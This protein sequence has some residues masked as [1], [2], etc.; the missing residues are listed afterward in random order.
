[1][2]SPDSPQSK[3]H[4]IFEKQQLANAERWLGL[5]EA[6]D[7]PSDI[8]IQDY[9]NLLRALEISL[10]KLETF[11]LAYRL[12]LQLFPNVI[13]YGDWERWLVYLQEAVSLSQTL[14]RFKEEA[15]LMRFMGNIYTFKGDYNQ[16]NQVYRQCM[17]KYLFLND[18]AN[19]ADTLTKL[20]T[21]DDYQGNTQES[22]ALL[23]EALLLS[24]SINDS[25][26]LMQIN[27]SLSSVYY[28][29]REWDQGI[30][31]A[32]IAY[33][34]AK[35][36]G[37]SQA[38]MQ[39]L[40]N[41]GAFHIE[42]GNWREVDGISSD[43]EVAL[44]KAGDVIRLGQFKN[45]LGIAAF[46][47]GQYFVAER[48]WQDALQINSQVNQPIELARIYNNLGMVYTKL[49]ELDAAEDMLKQAVSIFEEKGDL[50]NL[51][52]TLDNLADVYKAQ[53]DKAEF[54]RV[55]REALRLLPENSSEPHIQNLVEIINGR[56][57]SSS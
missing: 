40:I 31:S 2:T 48:A 50:F 45:N 3:W 22:L 16:A 53:G 7:N 57:A 11:D 28:K 14:N 32:E 30:K 38:E 41:I 33:N 21:V 18:N 42:L 52:N 23:E 13:G 29:S 5:L 43:L 19:Y 24:H 4:E 26:V 6:E 54:Q 20:A 56:L 37:D 55:L 49:N 8:L 15:S 27:L 35:H 25:K 46:T 10:Q 9:D 44:T 12:I 39:A 17:E 34:L 1:M 36:I 51:A 47:Q